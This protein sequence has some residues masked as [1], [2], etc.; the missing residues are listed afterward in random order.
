MIQRRS[1]LSGLSGA[2]AARPVSPAAEQ[3]GASPVSWQ[4]ARH[5]EDDWMDQVPAKHRMVFDT[6][7]PD[8]FGHALLFGSNFLDTNKNAYGLDY[9]DVGLMIIV[10]HNSTPFAYNDVMWAK[11]GSVFA[12]KAGFTDPKTKESPKSN[13]F[14]ATGY[15][16][17]LA[18]NGVTLDS[19]IKRGLHIGV[20]RLATRNIAGLVAGATGGDANKINEELIANIVAN[21]RMVPAGI[22]A[23]NRAQE[24]GYTFAAGV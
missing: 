14:N 22:V 12:Q 3:S 20:C 17:A 4:P 16:S 21:A 2:F 24:R 9:T 19:M 10:R 23:V 1:F 15:G 5:A 8:G 13:L 18:S 7:T 11:Y 6:T